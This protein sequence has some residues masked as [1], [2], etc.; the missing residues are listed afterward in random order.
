RFHPLEILL[1][2]AMKMA[3]VVLLGVPA[4]AVLIFEMLLNGMAMFNHSNVRLPLC[5]DAFLRRIVVT[6]DMHRV[7]H[8]VIVGETNSNYGFNLSI[9]DRLFGSYR[10]QPKQGHDAMCIGL[11]GMQSGRADGLKELLFL[12]FARK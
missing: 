6:P 1:S 11:P 9:W 10:A 8:S 2:M 5:L 3:A 12:P 7:H 4:A